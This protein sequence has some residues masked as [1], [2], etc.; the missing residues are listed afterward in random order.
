MTNQH[1]YI[2]G[3]LVLLVIGVTG[4]WISEKNNLNNVL[5]RLSDDTT[6][7]RADI[8]EKCNPLTLNDAGKKAECEEALNDF[9]QMI[10]DYKVEVSTADKSY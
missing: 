3:I 1:K 2:I 8:A 4:L 6:K 9:D 7:S 5:G 10:A